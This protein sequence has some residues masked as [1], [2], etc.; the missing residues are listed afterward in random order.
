[1]IRSG[2]NK[3]RQMDAPDV[4][5]WQYVKER[6]RLV[7]YE[8]NEL[9]NIGIIAPAGRTPDGRPLFSGEAIEKLATKDERARIRDALWWDFQP[10]LE[11]QDRHGKPWVPPADAPHYPFDSQDQR[12]WAHEIHLNKPYGNLPTRH[13]YRARSRMEKNEDLATKAF[14]KVHR[15]KR[16]SGLR[17]YRLELH[18]L[19]WSKMMMIR[20][21]ADL[22]VSEFTLRKICRRLSIPTPPRGHFN[23][24]NPKDRV[25]RPKLP[26]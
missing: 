21:A 24:H 13:A 4:Y 25:R 2:G 10:H 9:L 19:V 16:D 1:M 3:G 22:K 15:K 8:M 5:E 6:L 26:R 20:A 23:H 18:D 11:R 12:A 17:Q 7:N 14:E